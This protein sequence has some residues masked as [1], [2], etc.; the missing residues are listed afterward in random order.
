MKV[1]IKKTKKDYYNVL[2]ESGKTKFEKVLE[3]SQVRFLIQ[4][5]DNEI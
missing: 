5:L 1:E 3:K 2:I 4:K